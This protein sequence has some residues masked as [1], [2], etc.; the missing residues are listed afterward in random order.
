MKRYHFFKFALLLIVLTPFLYVAR[1]AYDYYQRQPQIIQVAS[2]PVDLSPWA[3]ISSIHVGFSPEGRF[4]L[5]EQSSGF[6]RIPSTS[7][8]IFKKSVS[9]YDT[10]AR[11]VIL[12]VMGSECPSFADESHFIVGVKSAGT[13]VTKVFSLPDGKVLAVSPNDFFP[14]GAMTYQKILLGNE[15]SAVHLWDY[16]SIGAPKMLFS[17]PRGKSKEERR[18]MKLLEDKNTLYIRDW[19][20]VFMK[21]TIHFSD[22]LGGPPIQYANMQFWD[23]KQRKLRYKIAD[24]PQGAR[25]TSSDLTSASNGLCAWQIYGEVKLWDDTT[26]QFHNL[27]IARIPQGFGGLSGELSPVALSPDGALLVRLCSSYIALW[28]TSN[29]R[30]ITVISANPMHFLS[31]VAFS[32]DGKTLACGTGGNIQL[33]PIERYK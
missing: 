4:L 19:A 28:D 17:V 12:N 25:G 3:P 23:I 5:H 24:A 13:T 10:V 2:P 30:L 9:V 21:G 27:A 26:N 11:K 18:D 1:V 15:Q 29:G 33:W 32:P 31:C 16:T 6:D 8:V 22:M 7:R 20:P 14:I